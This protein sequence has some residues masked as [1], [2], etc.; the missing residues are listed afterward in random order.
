MNDAERQPSVNARGQTYQEAP[1][2]PSVTTLAKDLRL[3]ELLEI[4]QR[5]GRVSQFRWSRLWFA[6]ALLFSGGAVGGWVTAAPTSGI[7]NALVI[8]G[9]CAAAGLTAERERADS[10]AAIKTSFD[11]IL[12]SYAESMPQ[13]AALALGSEKATPRWRIILR[14]SKSQRPD[15]P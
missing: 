15:P 9:I 1:R 2:D 4:S 6:V 13:I 12:A 10:V 5:L 8:A 3:S 7:R 14:P 11:G